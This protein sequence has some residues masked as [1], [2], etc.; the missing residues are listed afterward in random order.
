VRKRERKRA[1]E[2]ATTQQYSLRW[3]NYLRHLTYSLDNHRLNDDFVDVSLCVDGRKIKAHK[4]VLS[5]CSSYFK[6]I[7]KENPHPHPVIIFK[8]IKFEDLNSIV[9]FMYQVSS[10][11][12][13]MFENTII[14][15][16]T[17]MRVE[18]SKG[19]G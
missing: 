13:Y 5:S 6:E 14:N 4:V 3:N 11:C 19:V 17:L 15:K 9:E 2:M 16:L 12:F 18:E 7:F 1:K 10:E 8:F